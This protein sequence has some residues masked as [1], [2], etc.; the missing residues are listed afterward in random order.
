MRGPAEAI[1][2]LSRLIPVQM[3]PRLVVEVL[4]EIIIQE[5]WHSASETPGELAE[6]WHKNFKNRISAAIHTARTESRFL[7]YELSFANDDYIQGSCF[8][9]PGDD[10]IIASAKERRAN[11]FEFI[12]EFSTLTPNEF[13]ILSGR[14]LSLFNVEKGYV[15]RV[16][17]DQGIDFFGRVPFGELLKPSA[18]T[19]GAEKQLKIWMV[20]QSKHYQATQVSTKDIRELV[21]SVSLAKSKVYAGS[22]DPLSDLQ[23]RTCDPVFFLFFTTGDISRD[24][25]DLL[26]KSG[27]IAM[28]GEQLAMFLADHGVGLVENRFD[29]RT[30]RSWLVA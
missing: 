30:F 2:I 8:V 27:V 16:S 9:E 4:Q 21:G 18:I 23:M 29:A 25:M 11:T 26:S 20:G 28:N 15:T 22:K 19:P 13:E 14:V 12:S 17:A 10:A 3:P 7:Q 6:R 24:A 5:S 1:K